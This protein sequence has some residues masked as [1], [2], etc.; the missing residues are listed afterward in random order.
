MSNAG[1]HYMPPPGYW[2]SNVTDLCP[3]TAHTDSRSTLAVWQHSQTWPATSARSSSHV[4][5]GTWHPENSRRRRRRSRSPRRSCESDLLESIKHKGA[6]DFKGL[7]S[8]PEEFRAVAYLPPSDVVLDI[9]SIKDKETRMAMCRRLNDFRREWLI[10]LASPSAKAFYQEDGFKCFPMSR[11]TERHFWDLF[12]RLPIATKDASKWKAV[13]KYVE[14]CFEKPKT[15]PSPK[16][17]GIGL[18]FGSGLY[19]AWFGGD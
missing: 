19:F 11:I 17:G 3:R 15:T 8:L 2:Q 9:H 6:E 10:P 16:K 14:A 4:P 13:L 12:H 18:G 1:G 7:F 5:A